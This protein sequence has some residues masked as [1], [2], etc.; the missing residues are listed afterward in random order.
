M[1]ELMQRIRNIEKTMELEPD[2]MKRMQQSHELRYLLKQL[3][4]IKLRKSA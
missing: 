2:R 4:Q 1:N 3:E